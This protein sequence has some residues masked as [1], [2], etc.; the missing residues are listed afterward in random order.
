MFLCEL[1]QRGQTRARKRRERLA[2]TPPFG[3][4]LMLDCVVRV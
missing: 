1:E 4:Q 2:K 3:S